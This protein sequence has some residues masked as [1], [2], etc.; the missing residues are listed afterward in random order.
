MEDE[1]L[2]AVREAAAADGVTVSDWVRRTLRE[3]QRRRPSGDV[4]AKLAAVRVAARHDFPTGDID[5]MIQE[6]ERGY[7]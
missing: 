7:A 1:E 5:Q 3:A 4:A 2:A 6:I